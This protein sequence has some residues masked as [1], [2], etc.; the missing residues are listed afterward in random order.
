MIGPFV[1][2]DPFVLTLV[3]ERAVF[4]GNIAFLILVL[5][6][7]KRYFSILEKVFVFLAICFKVEVLK[8]FKISC[9]FQIK[10]CQSPKR[11]AILKIPNAVRRTYVTSVGF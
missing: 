3:S 5:S 9:D 6:T 11:M 2:S 8:T 1:L 10:T 7:K 4:Y